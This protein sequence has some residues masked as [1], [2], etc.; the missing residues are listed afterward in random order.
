MGKRSEGSSITTFGTQRMNLLLEIKPKPIVAIPN[1]IYY[2]PPGVGK[3]YMQIRSAGIDGRK[4]K[5]GDPVYFIVS[6]RKKLD[7]PLA[8]P[9]RL[10]ST[11][12]KAG[13]VVVRWISVNNDCLSGT[14]RLR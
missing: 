3:Y 5:W 9:S 6:E 2:F 1:N 8:A 11:V 10:S 12:G 4:T 14:N 13:A 7:L